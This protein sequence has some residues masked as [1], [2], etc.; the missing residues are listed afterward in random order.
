[1]VVDRTKGIED[2][3]W[4][5]S[6]DVDNFKFSSNL[7]G[8][9]VKEALSNGTF[10]GDLCNILGLEK[11]IF[12]KSYYDRR[13]LM[14]SAVLDEQTWQRLSKEMRRRRG[15]CD[16]DGHIADIS[17]M[18]LANIAERYSRWAKERASVSALVLE[19]DLAEERDELK[20]VPP[21]QGQHCHELDE[22][23]R[24]GDGIDTKAS[25][26]CPYDAEESFEDEGAAADRNEVHVI[27]EDHV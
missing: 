9:A 3:L 2:K 27:E 24:D 17:I 11:V 26:K 25:L 13:L 5:S 4:Y 7:Y 10:D 18:R 1:M 8:Q 14:R 16:V 22:A 19:S 6:S 23:M 12:R 20:G 21:I 15:L